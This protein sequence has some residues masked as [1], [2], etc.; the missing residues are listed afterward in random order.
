MNLQP[1]PCHC[2]RYSFP[3][4]HDRLKCIEYTCSRCGEECSP[5]ERREYNPDSGRT[6][7]YVTSNCCNA[8]IEE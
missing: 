7:D 1:K 5:R 4:R 6:T 2:S 3:H 8:P